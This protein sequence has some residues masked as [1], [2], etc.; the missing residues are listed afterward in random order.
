MIGYLS[1]GS[2][3]AV[4]D[5]VAAFQKGLLNKK[6]RVDKGECLPW[7]C[8]LAEWQLGEVDLIRRA[9][10]KT[11]VWTF[12]IEQGGRSVGLGQLTF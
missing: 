3:G 4:A 5:R 11:L 10:V 12:G 7:L 2:P 8:D 9:A 1:I 6:I